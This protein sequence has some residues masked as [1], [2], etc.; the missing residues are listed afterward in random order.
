MQDGTIDSRFKVNERLREALNIIGSIFLA[1][2]FI[3]S[4]YAHFKFSDFVISFIPSYIPFHAFW[5]YFCGICL[6]GGSVGLLIPQSRR[7]AALLSVLMVMGWFFL[8]HLPG[9]ISNI[10]DKSDRMGLYESFLLKSIFC[11]PKYPKFDGYFR[12]TLTVGINSMV[13]LSN[14]IYKK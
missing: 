12:F 4:G 2:F 7:A 9:Y 14:A 6:L 5:T 13:G 11:R 1:S 8:L 3:A 10:N